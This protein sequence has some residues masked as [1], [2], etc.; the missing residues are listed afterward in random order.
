V[1]H[2]FWRNLLNGG[3]PLVRMFRYSTIRPLA[4]ATCPALQASSRLIMHLLHGPTTGHIITIRGRE[5]CNV[6]SG[7]D[8]YSAEGKDKS[9]A[10]R[11]RKITEGWIQP[12]KDQR[13]SADQLAKFSSDVVLPSSAHGRAPRRWQRSRFWLRNFEMKSIDGRLL[14]KENADGTLTRRVSTG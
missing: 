5:S 13:A 10:D 7:A 11:K 8:D 3:W 12:K 6:D 9:R 2:D 1:A 4:R 14:T